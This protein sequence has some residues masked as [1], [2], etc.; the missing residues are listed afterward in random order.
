MHNHVKNVS[1]LTIPI[2]KKRYIR[3]VLL[4]CSKKLGFDMVYMSFCKSYQF[5]VVVHC[6]LYGWVEAKSL[7][8]FFFQI[9]YWKI[10]CRPDPNSRLDI[11][12]I[13]RNLLL[14]AFNLSFSAF[15]GLSLVLILVRAGLWIF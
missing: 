4:F 8:T 6:D 3:P 5:F 12:L 15:S 13:H 14:S 9:V 11:L 7:Y 2:L 10:L 1:A